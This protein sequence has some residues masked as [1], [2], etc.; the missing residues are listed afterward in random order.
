MT[1]FFL[2]VL[3]R[4]ISSGTGDPRGRMRLLGAVFLSLGALLDLGYACAG[5]AGSHSVR[6][7]RRPAPREP[8]DGR[9]AIM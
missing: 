7:P 2:A 8:C 6:S 9:M 1:L 4:F 3:A 5:G